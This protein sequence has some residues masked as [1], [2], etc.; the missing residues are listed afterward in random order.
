MEEIDII[1]PSG[2]LKYRAIELENG[3]S[4]LLIHENLGEGESSSYA[5]ASM[6]VRVGSLHDPPDIQGPSHFLEHM[7]LM[8]CEKYLGQS[9]VIK[10]LDQLL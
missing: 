10:L 2:N 8:G 7:L 4:A 6:A 9:G 3:L 1:H 5:A